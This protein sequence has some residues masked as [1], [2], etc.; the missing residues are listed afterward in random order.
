ME[1]FFSLNLDNNDKALFVYSVRNAIENEMFDLELENRLPSTNGE[2]QYRWNYINRDLMEL[3]GSTLSISIR[4][5]RG[6][7]L[8][9]ITDESTGFSFSLMSSK[10]LKAL[11]K[12]LPSNIHYL[13]ALLHNNSAFAPPSQQLSFLSQDSQRDKSLVEKIRR[14]L[15]GDFGQKYHL[16]IVFDCDHRIVTQVKLL[17]LDDKLQLVYQ[18]DWSKHLKEPLI[19][20]ANDATYIT[21]YTEEEEIPISIK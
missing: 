6:W 14:E 1:S 5:R 11:Q 4:R 18:E 21:N 15:L 8:A 16:L 10:N 2:G 9:I 3:L 19:I 20:E 17:L 7:Q 13:E 12:K